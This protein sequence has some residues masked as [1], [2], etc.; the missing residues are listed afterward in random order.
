MNGAGQ[1]ALVD[2]GG[3]LDHDPVDRDGVA[4]AWASSAIAAVVRLRAPISGHRPSSAS[5]TISSAVSR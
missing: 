5:A 3:A 4:R 1:H 2:A